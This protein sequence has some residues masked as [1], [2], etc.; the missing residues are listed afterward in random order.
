MNRHLSAEEISALLAGEELSGRRAAGHLAECHECRAEVARL[1][2]LLL[3]FGTAAR[4][5][6]TASPAFRVPAGM[7]ERRWMTLNRALAGALA[8]A[9]LAVVPVY[10]MQHRAPP[11]AQSFEVTDAI[12]LQQ[13]D[14]Q[15]ARSI[16]GSMEPLVALA[17]S[18]ADE[19]TQGIRSNHK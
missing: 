16:P 10:R 13:V 15:L 6:Q 14:A 11:V 2:S 12:L 3:D 19:N 9:A 18:S 4:G 7:P 1:E 17:W 8:A 5:L